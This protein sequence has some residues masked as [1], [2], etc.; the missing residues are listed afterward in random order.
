M[1]YNF[2]EEM[3][4]S[5]I[6]G[7]N[8][9]FRVFTDPI[10]DDHYL[11]MTTGFMSTSNFKVGSEP[12]ETELNKSPELVRALQQYD[13]E[14][15]IVWIPTILNFPEKGMIYPEGNIEGWK[16][17]YASVIQISEEEQK[18]YPIPNKEGEYF[19]SKLDVE[20]SQ[21]FDNNKFHEACIAMGL[22]TKDYKGS[23]MN[24]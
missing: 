13:S 11:C 5:P 10:S 9:C 22:I 8:N 17:C 3:I 23:L 14:R 16:W 24:A 12:L 21:K 7:S 4:E 19:T 15:D 1:E 20:N 2:K 6:D 18:N